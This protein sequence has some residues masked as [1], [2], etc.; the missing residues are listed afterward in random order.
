MVVLGRN[1]GTLS[2][3]SVCDNIENKV[4]NNLKNVKKSMEREKK[5][6]TKTVQF[7]KQ[8][9]ANKLSS[10]KTHKRRLTLDSKECPL[11]VASST[12]FGKNWFLLFNDIFVHAGYA[13]HIVHDL[14]TLWIESHPASH[15]KLSFFSPNIFYISNM[16]KKLQIFFVEI[17]TLFNFK[18]YF[19]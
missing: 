5:F 13:S 9:G 14:Q 12:G 7:W 6:K 4:I 19:V 8:T 1:I 18:S 17:L 16:S 10:L 3:A 2:S 11:N 15:S